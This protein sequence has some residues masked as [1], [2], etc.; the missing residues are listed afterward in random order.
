MD[1]KMF[2]KI[3]FIMIYIFFI[4]IIFQSGLI[5]STALSQTNTFPFGGYFKQ[6]SGDM[7]VYKAENVLD[8]RDLLTFSNNTDFRYPVVNGMTYTVQFINSNTSI[9][10]QVK[11]TFT[12][13]STFLPSSVIKDY[14]Y[15]NYAFDNV[16]AVNQYVQYINTGV[17]AYFKASINGNYIVMNDKYTDSYKLEPTTV[18][19]TTTYNWQ[20]G[21]LQSYNETGYLSNNTI[22]QQEMLI[23]TNGSTPGFTAMTAIPLFLFIALMTIYRKRRQI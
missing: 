3:K 12:N 11:I 1:T 5:H 7:N 20:T 2:L 21:W 6:K 18:Y 14:Y 8:G 16:S 22:Y 10:C 17:S 13:G 15:I 9:Y 4:C 23:V 19:T